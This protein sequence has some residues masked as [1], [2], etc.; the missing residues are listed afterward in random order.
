MSLPFCTQIYILKSASA[1]CLQYLIDKQSIVQ[2]ILYTY[3][4]SKTTIAI[5]LSFYV[6]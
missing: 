3:S 2:L 4:L 6:I 1:Y 5:N